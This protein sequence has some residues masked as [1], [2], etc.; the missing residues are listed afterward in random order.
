MTC[1]DNKLGLVVVEEAIGRTPSEGARPNALIIRRSRMVRRWRGMQR[2]LT[3][4]TPVVGARMVTT[5]TTA[6]AGM[7]RWRRREMRIT[8]SRSGC[9]V[10]SA[11]YSTTTTTTTATVAADLRLLGVVV[12]V[13]NATYFMREGTI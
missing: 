1:F 3:T 8:T 2:G 5:T 9:R 4:A 12:I 6:T 13:A 11:C 7:M 10:A